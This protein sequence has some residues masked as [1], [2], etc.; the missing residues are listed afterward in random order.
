MVSPTPDPE[1]ILRQGWKVVSRQWLIQVAVVVAAGLGL[2]LV[3]SGPATSGERSPL[4][5]WIFLAVGVA[6]LAIG[7]WFRARVLPTRLRAAGSAAEAAGIVTGMSILI[8][9]LAITPAFLG[10]ALYLSGDR[11]GFAWLC[12][13]SLAGHWVFRPRHGDWQAMIRG[14]GR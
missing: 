4:F 13:L 12:A 5:T 1:A 7:W 11:Q 14:V 8:V 9:S 2:P 10:V 6:D 3:W